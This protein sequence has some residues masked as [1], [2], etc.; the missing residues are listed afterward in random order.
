MVD[1]QRYGT[2]GNWD[3]RLRVTVRNYPVTSLIPM[4]PGSSPLGSDKVQGPLDPPKRRQGLHYLPMQK[5]AKMRLR[6]SSAVVA[7]VMAS[8]GWSAA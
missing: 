3:D 8:I 7:P 1:I 4:F 6:M 5:V 2:S